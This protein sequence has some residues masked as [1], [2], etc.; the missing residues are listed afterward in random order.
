MDSVNGGVIS[1]LY[2]V[3]DLHL[4]GQHPDHRLCTQSRL[5]AGLVGH[6]RVR[7]QDTP[8]GRMVLLFAGDIIDFLIPHDDPEGFQPPLRSVAEGR[9]IVRRVCSENPAIFGTQGLPERAKCR[10]CLTAW[11]SRPRA[12]IP[13]GVERTGLDA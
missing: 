4:G 9:A 12:A 7:C 10:A 8:Q 6:V 3:S 13:C 1:E 2:V 5:L 11:E